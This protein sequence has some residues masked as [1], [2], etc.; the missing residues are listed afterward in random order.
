MKVVELSRGVG[1]GEDDVDTAAAAASVLVKST[2]MTCIAP[3]T[4]N[5]SRS[6]PPFFRPAWL[7]TD[8][9]TG[10][11]TCTTPSGLPFSLSCV[12]SAACSVAFLLS[13]LSA[14][15][16]ALRSF[17]NARRSLLHCRFG[18]GSHVSYVLSKP[19]QRMKYSG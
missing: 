1:L 13:S 14:F 9:A 16:L 8:S 18:R 10:S 11:A 17:S 3:S 7:S 12:P 5:C 2:A 15:S 4:S 6:S 19:F